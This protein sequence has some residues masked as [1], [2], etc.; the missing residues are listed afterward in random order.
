MVATEGTVVVKIGTSSLTDPQTGSLRLSV[1]GPL[2]EVLTR[3]RNQGYAVILVSS[4]AVGIGCA[5]LGLRQ[6]PTAIAEK[7]AVAAVG[8]GRLI[9]LYDDLFSALNQPIA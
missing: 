2:V 8:Q 4:G 5:R 7:Q 1:L 3:L 9:R 6:R